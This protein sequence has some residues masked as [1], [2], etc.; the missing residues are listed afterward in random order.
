LAKLSALSL[1]KKV[2]TTGAKMNLPPL[3][4]RH[5]SKYNYFILLL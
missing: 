2:L 4:G 5:D 1:D 3:F